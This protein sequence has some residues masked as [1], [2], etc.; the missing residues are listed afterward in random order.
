MD[1]SGSAIG[2]G[3]GGS[4][5]VSGGSSGISGPDKYPLESLP[6]APVDTPA[7]ADRIMTIPD[8]MFRI[9]N[10][11]IQIG[12]SS[13]KK[14]NDPM[15]ASSYSTAVQHRIDDNSSSSSMVDIWERVFKLVLLSLMFTLA[16][17]IGKTYPITDS[18]SVL[19]SLH[20]VFFFLLLFFSF[21]CIK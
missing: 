9:S 16:V 8:L 3:G 11:S 19:L 15:V 12:M 5:G 17:A 4:V 1:I 20:F 2:G 7:P 13:R 6:F 10:R 21:S 18:L 14:R